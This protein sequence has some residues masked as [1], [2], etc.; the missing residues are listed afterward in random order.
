MDDPAEK[1]DLVYWLFGYWIRRD[2]CRLAA[3]ALRATDTADGY[4]PRIWSLTVFFERYMLYGASDTAEDFGPKEP[5]ELK[6]VQ[7]AV[8]QLITR[9]D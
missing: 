1:F 7:P 4:T 3:Q 5:I 6:P 9:D 2:A 8:Q